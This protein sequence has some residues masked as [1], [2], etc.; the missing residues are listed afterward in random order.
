M[1]NVTLSISL[2]TKSAIIKVHVLMFKTNNISGSLNDATTDDAEETPF[3][4]H[5]T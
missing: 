5:D 2:V 4:S 3:E 1:S